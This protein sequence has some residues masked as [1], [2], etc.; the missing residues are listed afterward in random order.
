MT[1]HF[2]LSEFLHTDQTPLQELNKTCFKGDSVAQRNLV[3]LATLLEVVRAY[4]GKPIVITSGY[5]CGTLNTAVGGVKNSLH[6]SGRACDVRY[7][8]SLLEKLVTFKNSV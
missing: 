3:S 2:K 6:L 7:D 4:H 8:V 1:N 5:R